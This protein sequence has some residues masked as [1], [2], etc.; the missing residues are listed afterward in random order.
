MQ[1]KI[2]FVMGIVGHVPH[3]QS[4]MPFVFSEKKIKFKL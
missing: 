1:K 4:T 3:G 2:S